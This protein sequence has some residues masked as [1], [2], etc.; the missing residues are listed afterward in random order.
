[1]KVKSKTILMIDGSGTKWNVTKRTQYLAVNST[2]SNGEIE[3]A[4]EY[5]LAS[6]GERLNEIGPNKFL[7]ID[8]ARTLWVP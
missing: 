2:D 3:G 6:T 4:S 5:F 8:K 7:T 1:M